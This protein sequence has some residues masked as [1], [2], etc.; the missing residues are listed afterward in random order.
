MPLVKMINNLSADLDCMRPSMLET[1]LESVAY[2][3]NRKNEQLKFYEFGRTYQGAGTDYK[4][5]EHLAIFVSGTLRPDSWADTS[6]KADSYYI[7]GVI[8]SLF[9]GKKL[10]IKGNEISV[11]GK[12][13]GRFGAVPEDKLKQFD[14]KKDVFFADLEWN[15]IKEVFQQAN[16]R[17]KAIS[18]FPG[19][20][21]D[22]SLV[23]DKGVTYQTVEKAVNKAASAK[24]TKLE[25]F[26][27]Y[28]GDKLEPGKKSYAIRLHFLDSKKTITDEV[29]DAD[30][31]KIIKSLEKDCGA[32]IRS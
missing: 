15:N 12:K 16:I 25:L 20:E 6:Q 3:L 11:N 31:Q 14:I 4:E 22:L 28:D 29:V 1:A 32:L 7:R 30:I 27:I 26:D 24:M 21:R 23:L 8:E 5:Q 13:I 17:F 19:T 18:K 2:N 9:V 10:K